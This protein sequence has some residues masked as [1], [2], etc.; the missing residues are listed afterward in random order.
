MKKKELGYLV[1]LGSVWG[2]AECG[3]GIGL[4]ACAASTSGSVMT[5]VALFFIAAAWAA[6]G[7][8]TLNVALVTA[9]AIAFKMFDAI[10]LGLPI[11]SSAVV[12]PAFAF[13]LEGAALVGL[14]T[15]V[16][17]YLWR[18]RMSRVF[19]G[20][21][22]AFVAAAAF[23][24]VKLVSGMPACV[25]PGTAV[26]LAWAYGPLAVG[27]AMLTVP[28]GLGASEKALGFATRER[29]RIPVAVAAS[30]ALMIALRAI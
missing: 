5:A 4:R 12:H 15:L 20:G 10:L 28:L 14:G 29:W 6:P 9:F 3:L 13:V 26:P 17:R 24:L 19:W 25:V 7:R 1:L 18:S 30:L 2:L 11:G 27:L 16:V 21:A 23:P 22:S 8:N